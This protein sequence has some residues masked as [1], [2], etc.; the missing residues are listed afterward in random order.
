METKYRLQ[1]NEEF[2]FSL[3]E[4]EIQNLDIQQIT[5]NSLHLIHQNQSKTIEVTATDFINK[6][7]TVKINSSSYRV[8][9]GTPL[10]ALIEAMGLSLGEAVAVNDIKAPMPGLILDVP[11]KAGDTVKEGDYL[12]VLEAM[13]MENALTAPRDGVVKAVAIAKGDTVDKGQLLIEM[14]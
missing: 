6:T 1:V 5:D 13:K 2:D 9:I 4:N 12:L 14:E 11:V 7:Y 10:D 3:T 8:A